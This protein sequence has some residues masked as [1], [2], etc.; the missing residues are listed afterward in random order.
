MVKLRVFRDNKN[1]QRMLKLCKIA[2]GTDSLMYTA[3]NYSLL[4]MFFFTSLGVFISRGSL[5]LKDTIRSYGFTLHKVFFVK[6][7]MYLSFTIKT[8]HKCT[9]MRVVYMDRIPQRTRLQYEYTR[10][11]SSQNEKSLFCGFHCNKFNDRMLT[12]FTYE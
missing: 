5:V 9:E 4:L 3:S 1:L 10:E 6:N 8:N 2:R 11:E 7:F 12:S